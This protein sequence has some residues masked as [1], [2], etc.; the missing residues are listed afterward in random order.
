MWFPRRRLFL[1]PPLAVLVIDGCGPRGPSM[2]AIP[3][4]ASGDPAVSADTADAAVKA[5]GK[6]PAS[7]QKT[8]PQLSPMDWTKE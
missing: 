1:V 5:K 4:A 7:R 8:L 3:S 2:L 6:K